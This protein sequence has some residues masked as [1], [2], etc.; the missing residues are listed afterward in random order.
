MPRPVSKGAPLP[1]ISSRIA[2][3][4]FA[5]KG[6]RSRIGQAGARRHAPLRSRGRGVRRDA[7][8]ASV[9]RLAGYVTGS[10][11]LD[12][13]RSCAIDHFEGTWGGL[14]AITEVL[15]SV[16]QPTR[17]SGPL[18]ARG[19]PG[20]LLHFERHSV[21]LQGNDGGATQAAIYAANPGRADRCT[22]AA[23]R[24]QPVRRRSLPDL[25]SWVRTGDGPAGAIYPGRV[26]GGLGSVRSSPPR[27]DGSRTTEI[28]GDAYVG[29]LEGRGA[30]LWNLPSTCSRW[31]FAR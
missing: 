2:P 24:R 4:A 1:T 11:L 13:S 9:G 30:R 14:F 18:A 8:V 10:R 28:C 5:D 20:S 26:P 21:C 17:S 23:V 3:L 7:G 16:C 15:C 27:R 25:G 19:Q 29:V 6:R 12:G 31:L 22:V